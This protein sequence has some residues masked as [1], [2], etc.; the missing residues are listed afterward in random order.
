MYIELNI[1][2]Y[3]LGE[4]TDKENERYIEAVQIAIEEEYPD[5]EV[6]IKLTS[7]CDSNVY[8]ADCFSSYEIEQHIREI[9]NDVWDKSELWYVE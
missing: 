7:S 8:Y 4:N 6:D 5:A 9:A 2:E 1:S 3:T